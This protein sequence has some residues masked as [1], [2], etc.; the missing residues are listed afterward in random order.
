MIGLPRA[1]RRSW[2]PELSARF[3]ETPVGL[4]M[5]LRIRER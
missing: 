4:C 2:G 3:R 1:V 5:E